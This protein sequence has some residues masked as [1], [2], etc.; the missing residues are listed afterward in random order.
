MN[1]I[2]VNYHYFRESKSSNGIYPISKKSFLNQIDLLSRDY[3][4]ILQE[5]VNKLNLPNQKKAIAY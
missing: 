5:D 1:L 3:E 4:F 2:S